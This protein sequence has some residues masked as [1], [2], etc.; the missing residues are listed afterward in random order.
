MTIRSRDGL[1]L[2]AALDRTDGAAAT[3]VMCHPHPR[4]GGTMNAPLLLA[5]RDEL[6]ARNWNVLRFNFR[7][8]GTSEGE[9]ATGTE[10]LQ[11]VLGAIDEAQRLGQPIALA[12]WSFGG[13]VAL[14]ITGQLDDL[15]GCA[16]IAP[17]MDANPEYTDGVP[18]DVE[19]RCPVLIVMGTNDEQVSPERAREW[20][21][22]HDA[23]FEEVKGANHFFW[24]K[25]EVL[26]ALVCD[27][28]DER[29]P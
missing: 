27:W 24:A 23:T 21:Q 26:T 28:L 13:S 1:E 17:G 25:Y 2:E 5:L 7:G 22:R 3:L 19:P 8:V 12:G 18:D 15:L 4:W 16:A 14:R 6:L 9:M 29:I 10:E 11:D 20:A